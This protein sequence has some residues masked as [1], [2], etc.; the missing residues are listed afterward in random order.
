MEA[1]PEVS[2]A[3]AAAR[4]VQA[5]FVSGSD[6]QVLVDLAAVEELGRIVDGLRIAGAASVE[7]RSRPVL[8]EERLSFRSGARDG[9]HLVQQVGRI[10]HSEAKRRVGLGT[11]LAPKYSILQE[12]LPG[13]YAPLTDAVASGL[14]G[15]ES[16]RV[17]VNARKSIS[18]RVEAELLDGMVIQLTDAAMVNDTE[19]LRDLAAAWA[20]MT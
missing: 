5:L 17:I 14:V 11:A 15:L 10:G 8:G 4:S 18:K 1:T 19:Q 9:A 13:K 3:I 7:R 2:A 20:P 6:E 12:P 16:A